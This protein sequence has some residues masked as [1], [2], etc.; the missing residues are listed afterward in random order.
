MKK[1]LVMFSGGLDSV[2]ATHL[3]KQQGIEIVALHFVLPFYSG[4][5]LEHHSVQRYAKQLDVRLRIEEEGEE[6]LEMIRNPTFGFGKHA[7]P[8]VDCRIYRLRKAKKIMEQEGAS[9]IAT[10]EVVGQR[11]MSQ[12]M[13][14]LYRIEQQAGLKGYL[15]R[16]L[17][18]KL[19]SPTVPEQEGIVDRESLF[20]LSGRSRK[21]QLGYARHHGLEHASPAGGC[22]LTNVE[23]ARRYDDLVRYSPNYTLTDF[24][25][26]A[27]GR[28]FRLSP[29]FIVIVSRDESENEIL[30]RLIRPGT[31]QFLLADVLGPLAIGVGE[32]PCKEHV[33]LAAALCA[34]YSKVRNEERVRVKVIF[35]MEEK[36]VTV[37]PASNEMCNSLRVQS[38]QQVG[39]GV[40]Q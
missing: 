25:R 15:L 24:Q 1:A 18:A 22:V 40:P 14:C 11:P 27:Y 9:F 34:R 5:G 3:L 37:T 26:I 29:A 32:T 30:E 16:P 35:G 4:L 8:C 19:L 17:S 2:T 28:H 13:D 12:R 21:A 38:G 39:M 10:G 23:T 7:N 31:Y 33:E 20:G 36:V 6:F